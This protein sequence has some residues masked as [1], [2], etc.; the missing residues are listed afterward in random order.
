[1]EF[2][3]ALVV[4]LIIGAIFGFI[5][6]RG[7]FCMNSA[8][9]DIILLKE[10]KLAKAVVVSLAVLMV[11][12]AIFAFGEVI[13]LAPKPFKPWG[14]I[15]GGLIF[16][17]G[18]VLAA[19]CA[20]GTTYRVGEGMMGSFVAAIGLTT[21]AMMTKFGILSQAMKDLQHVVVGDGP[22][23][24]LFGEFD[25]DLTPMLMLIVGLVGIVLMFIFW[26]LPA[27]KKKRQANEPL[28]KTENFVESTF[29]KGY[30]WWVTGILI[31]IILTAGYVASNGVI[32]ITGGW[33][34]I[35]LWLITKDSVMWTG[36]I[37]FGIIIGAFAS[38]YIGGEFKFRVPKDGFMLLKQFIGGGLMGFG[39]VVAMGCNITNILGGIPQL[40]LHSIVTGAFIVFGSW[41]AAYLLFMWRQE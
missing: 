4:G 16:G 11:G 2:W 14:A 25:A 41:L 8:F 18:M 36:F 27:I 19:G 39:A 37:I 5:L 15:V 12:F 31:G 21:G 3:Y 6:Q 24:T 29:K 32:G 30:P 40:S 28:I 34:N 38:A 13:D 33:M 22:A 23:L 17:I 1:M 26:G 35:E 20:S 9:R 7:R 10:F